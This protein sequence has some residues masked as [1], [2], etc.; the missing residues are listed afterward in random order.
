MW[1]EVW[2]LDAGPKIECWDGVG[3][4]RSLVLVT[5]LSQDEVLWSYSLTYPSDTTYFYIVVPSDITI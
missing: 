4:M 5:D 3:D 1:G 2:V